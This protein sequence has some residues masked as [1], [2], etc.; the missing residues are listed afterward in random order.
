MIIIGCSLR[1][2]DTARPARELYVGHPFY[3]LSRK[4]AETSGQPWLILSGRHGLVHPDQVLEPYRGELIG[5]AIDHRLARQV[6]WM[7]G[8]QSVIALCSRRYTEALLRALPA[9]QVRTPLAGLRGS[10]EQCQLLARM[11]VTQCYSDAA[12]P[13]VSPRSGT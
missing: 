9:S 6:R 4:A 7:I 3:A 1:Q 5:R 11:I 13:E 10:G 12:V 8:G 2:A